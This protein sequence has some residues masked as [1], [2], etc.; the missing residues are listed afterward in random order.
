MRVALLANPESGDGEGT[1]VDRLLASRGVD[2]E[3]FELDRCDAA[4]DTS[5]DRI[6]VAGG[7]GSI[8]CA[9]EAA[10]RAGVPLAVIPV[11]TANDFA[12]AVG[13]PQEPE[14]AIELAVDGSRTRRLDLGM[15]GED[16]PFVN[17][18]SAGLS[19]AAARN[20]HGLKG[21]L[22]PLAYA[23]GALRAGLTT[24]PVRCEVRCDG[25]T[26]FSGNAW[27]VTVGLTGAFGGGA[28]VDADP[29][30]GLL[31]V[32]VIEA[33]SRL[34]LIAHAYGMRAGSIEG[35]RGVV[36]GSGREVEVVT[37]GGTGFNVD[38]E[39]VEAERLRLSLRQRAYDVVVG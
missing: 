38:G 4:V 18:V 30:D 28:E 11:G 29:R 37:H 3:V 34:R 2:V 21:L 24:A 10:G 16:R 32:V 7:D 6:A 36:T 27:Q 5:P 15:A 22:G 9:A 39:L 14:P 26:L 25:E 13:I 1:E 17:A 19:P 33:R 23:V 35:Q 12:R 31:D 20:A 8:A